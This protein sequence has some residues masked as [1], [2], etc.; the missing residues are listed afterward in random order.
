MRFESPYILLLLILTIPLLIAFRSSGAAFS[1]SGLTHLKKMK[2]LALLG[3]G[4]TSWKRTIPSILRIT[5]V[6]L[7][8]LAMA[9]PQHGRKETEVENLGVDIILTLDT[10]GSMAAMD[11][12]VGEKHS[13]RLD[14]VKSVVSE[15]LDKRPGD[16][17][18]MVVFGAE[19]FTQA[20]LTLD[21][22]LLHTLLNELEIGMAGDST[23]VGDAIAISTDRIKDL[24]AKS[25]VI[26]LVTD[27]RS[28]SGSIPPKKAAEIAATFGVKIY[29]IGIGSNGPA[30]FLVDSLFGKQVVYENVDLDEDTLKEIAE[31]TNAK[32]FRAMDT[33]NLEKIYSEI[34]SL[35]KSEAKVKEYMEYDELF[36]WFLIPAIILFLLE[37][38]LTRTRLRKIP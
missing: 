34:D 14:A 20:P 10:S 11:F 24:K 13:T 38:I 26:V 28:N 22:A 23:A 5:V 32:Y 25:K 12:T 8:I 33:K 35:E 36:V 15:F 4:K 9:R 18:G 29:T 16:R 27:G 3:L 21:H 19:A 37:V 30:P 6:I 31:I 7:V 1:F 17:I 2:D